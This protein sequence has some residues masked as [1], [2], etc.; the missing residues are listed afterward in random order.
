MEKK[1]AIALNNNPT[2]LLNQISETH[3]P[4]RHKKSWLLGR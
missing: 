2:D 4:C 3:N 1:L